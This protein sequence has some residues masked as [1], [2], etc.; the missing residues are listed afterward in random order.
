M[1]RTSKWPLIAA[2]F[3]AWFPILVP[4]AH[5]AVWN[6]STTASSNSASDAQINWREGQPPSSINDSAR[7]M[8]A[9]LASYRD[10]ISGLLTST[11]TASAYSVTTN[12]N[13]CASP[14]T[15]PQDGQQLAVTVNVTNGSAPTLTADACSTY[16]IQSASGVAVGA[17]T[18]IQGSP[19]T[20]RFS[21]ANSAWMLRDF[22]GTALTVPLGGLVPYT[23]STVPNSNFVFPAGQCLSTTTYASYWTA[24]G[25]PASGTCS[26]GQ[27]EIIDLSGSIPAGLDTMPGFSAANRLT[28]AAAGCGT[29][30]TSVGARCANGNES[31]ALAAAQIPTLTLGV[32]VSG[33]I[34]GTTST[35]NE[36]TVTPGS[37]IAASQLAGSPFAGLSVSGSFSGSGSGSTNNTAGQAHSIVPPIVGVTYLL[38]VI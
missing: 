6:W 10:D 4:L 24:L 20:F 16:P 2:I 37:S 28:N 27:F 25:S 21:V 9:A 34:T 19:Y 7:A 13:L 29:A 12:Q 22:F 33:S 36:V 5:S 35:L 26:G 31:R 15:V 18:L 17:A 14:A 38:R 23:L 3:V 32:S 8:M 1:S 11:G 30:M